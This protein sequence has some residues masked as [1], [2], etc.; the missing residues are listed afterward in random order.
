[1]YTLRVITVVRAP[2]ERCFDLA[3]SVDA[4][5]HSAGRSGERAV[6]GRTSGLLGLG[7]RI[8]F[9]GRH[10]GVRQ[11]L[12]SRVTAFER[13]AFF[14]DR[15]ER[16]AFSALEHDHLFT[17]EADQT[18]MTDVVRFVAPLGPL[19]WAAERLFVAGHLRRFL[20][21]RGTLL[22]RWAE[23]DEWRQFVRA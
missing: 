17:T 7:D 4:H 18:V 10:F 9:E 22:K 23:S 8:T 16:G 21:E 6:D 5:V 3:R 1:M 20:V 19:G 2:L 15:M 11:R 13:P 12:T 14:Q